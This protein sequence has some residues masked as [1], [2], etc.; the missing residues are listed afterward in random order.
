VAE[1]LPIERGNPDQRFNTTLVDTEYIFDFRWNERADA[2]YMNVFDEEEK[3][4]LHGVKVVL[5]TLLGG[6]ASN[7][8][9]DFPEGVLVAYDTEGTNIDAGRD[10]FGADQRVVVIFVPRAEFETLVG[11]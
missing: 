4:L 1:E 9:A 8:I 5:G 2:W 3:A 11:R 10:D 7:A 6:H